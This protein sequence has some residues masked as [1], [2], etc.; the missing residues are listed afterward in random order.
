[1]SKIPSG[2]Q[3]SPIISQALERSA[4]AGRAGRPTAKEI[5]RRKARVLD[6]ASEL[7]VGLGFVGTSMTDI[8]R[9]SGVALG[10]LYN[11][12][13]SK[14]DLFR[15]V[16]RTRD[17]QAV[18]RPTLEPEH[19]LTAALLR[20]AHYIWDVTVRERAVAL[21]R[22]MIMESHRFPD[23][24][25]A[26]LAESLGRFNAVVSMLF[27]GLAQAGLVPPGDQRDSAQLFQDVILGSGTPLI[28]VAG[29]DCRPDDATLR[30]RIAF[31]I[32]GGLGR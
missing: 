8:A 28:Y 22:L 7:F 27:D 32:A 21:I 10:T 30:A 16:A 1:M 12:F 20:I 3:R 23:L 29:V 25:P 4:R 24:M 13:G 31:F 11:H 6:V 14:E 17:D 19:D 2:L 15:T 26:L 9:Q 18:A 5:E